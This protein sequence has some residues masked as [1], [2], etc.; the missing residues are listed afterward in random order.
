MWGACLEMG[1]WEEMRNDCQWVEG[2]FG[3]DEN[4]LKLVV[5]MVLKPCG[6]TKNY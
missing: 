4:V 3:G 5:D 2:F 1:S 6:Y